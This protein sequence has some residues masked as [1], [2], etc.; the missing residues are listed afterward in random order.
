MI[1]LAI[2]A[3]FIAAGVLSHSG[4]EAAECD[5]MLAYTGA[6]EYK[7]EIGER[8]RHC[9]LGYVLDHDDARKLPIWVVELLVPDRF[10]GP[11]DRKEQGNPFAPDPD[12]EEGKR[13]ELKDYKGSG[14]DRGHMAPA[15]TMKFSR[16]ATEESFYLSNMAPQVGI[17]LNRHIWA[18]LEK[19]TRTWT[20][21]RDEIVVI[22][23]PIFDSRRAKTIG[24]NKVAVPD[25]FFKIA[26]DPNPKRVIAFILP[27]RKIDREGRSSWETLRDDYIVTIA[28]IE[29]RTGLD[30]LTNLSRR[31]ERRLESMKSAMWPDRD[32]CKRN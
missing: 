28:D 8:S 23:G 19:L 20:C 15:A 10:V 5:D 26:Y 32:S 31:N 29:E 17:G 25:A 30:F 3:A 6:P 14:F 4:A 24:P 22:T 16:E 18:D 21:E 11:G 13:A 12:L 2:I 9:R 7:G 27:N 1:R